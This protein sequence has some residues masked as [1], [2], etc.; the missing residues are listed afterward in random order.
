MV[1]QVGAACTSTAKTLSPRFNPR[2]INHYAKAMSL[3][4]VDIMTVGHYLAQIPAEHT[5]P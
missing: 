4:Q 1:Q 3:S 2:R 5:G